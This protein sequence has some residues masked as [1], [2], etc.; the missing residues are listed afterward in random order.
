VIHAM[1]GEQD[2]RNMGGLRSKLPWTHLTM[3]VGCIA[4]AG[5]PPLAGFFSKDEILWSAF[6]IGGYGRIVWGVGMVAAAMTA[7]YMFRLYHMTFSGSFRG[8][9]EQEHHLHE[10]PRSMVMPL[11]VLALGSVLVG[12]VG[13]PAVL[14]GGNR[15]ERFLDP[16][17]EDARGLLFGASEHGALGSAVFAHVAHGVG[18][19]LGLMV[20]SVA[21][22]LVGIVLAWR[23]YKARP[24]IAERLAAA[25]PWAH[26]VLLNKYFVDGGDGEV[27]AGG[28]V[29]GVAWGVRDLVAKAS[30][31]WDRWIVDGLVNLT[32]LVLE[33]LS[34]L[35]RAVQNGLVQNYVWVMVLGLLLL[36]G[37]SRY[38]R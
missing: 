4:I 30:D 35:F 8:T 18:L 16:A 13:V 12:F 26:R 36:V 7:F 28:G 37:V 10:S 24:E 14:L 6:K 9:H 5:I 32:G 3:W 23:F 33:N 25:W 2:M 34:F 31:L 21:V 22:A 1:S 19:E 15:I 27:R 11:Q 38:V 29:N 17:F 20:G